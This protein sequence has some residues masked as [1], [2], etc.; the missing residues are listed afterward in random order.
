MQCRH[1]SEGMEAAGPMSREGFLSALSL[2]KASHHERRGLPSTR[3]QIRMPAL[4]G[5]PT[6]SEGP[7]SWGATFQYDRNSLPPECY[8]SIERTSKHEVRVCSP[9]Q[10]RRVIRDKGNS[11]VVL[12]LVLQDREKIILPQ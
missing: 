12:Q 1:K 8:L 4:L 9:D 5:Y 2:H 6:K 11:P 3:G 7:Q 10:R